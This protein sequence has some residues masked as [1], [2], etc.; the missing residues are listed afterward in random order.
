MKVGLMSGN[1]VKI[2]LAVGP[3][4]LDPEMGFNRVSQQRRMID[5]MNKGTTT[6]YG[7]Q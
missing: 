3:H 2:T 1:V 5:R 4:G 7:K 6:A